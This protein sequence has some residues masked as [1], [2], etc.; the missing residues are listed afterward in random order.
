MKALS[1]VISIGSPE[2]CGR[3]GVGAGRRLEREF[4][5]MTDDSINLAYV[6]KPSWKFWMLRLTG[7]VSFLLV[8]TLMC[9]QSDPF[10]CPGEKK[11]KLHI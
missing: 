8:S 7:W 11:W 2:F 9:Q 10:R 3:D 6:M 4:N 5:H 1:H